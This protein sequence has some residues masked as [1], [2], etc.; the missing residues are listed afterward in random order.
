MVAGAGIA[1]VV[2]GAVVGEADV[3]TGADVVD[4]VVEE[5]LGRMSTAINRM[6]SKLPMILFFNELPP[7]FIVFIFTK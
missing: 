3:V 7:V 2:T 5:Q 1:G 6:A 4:D